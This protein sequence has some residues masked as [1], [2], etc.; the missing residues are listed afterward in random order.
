MQNDIYHPKYAKEI[1]KW[2]LWKAA[3]L[4]GWDE[5]ESLLHDH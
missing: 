5:P 2:A 4:N 3:E 1:R